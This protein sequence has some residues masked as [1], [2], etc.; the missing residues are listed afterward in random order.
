[1]DSEVILS[2]TVRAERDI[3]PHN[4]PESTFH[5]G[6]IFAGMSGGGD[7]VYHSTDKVR[8][9]LSITVAGKVPARRMLFCCF[10]SG[11]RHLRKAKSV[12][13]TG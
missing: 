13:K 12:S 11:V 2:P 6:S 8:L 1:M 7:G 10:V 5:T 9:L 3:I 4:L